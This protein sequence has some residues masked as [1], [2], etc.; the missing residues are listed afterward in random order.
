[1]ENLKNEIKNYIPFNE[2]EE[3]DREIIIELLENEKDILTRDNKKCH[4][5]VSAWIVDSS[6]KK[7]LMCYHNIY[8]SW[9]WL[10]AI[11]ISITLG[12]GLED[13]LMEIVI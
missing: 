11:T 12:L 6:R 7:V 10:G 9:A 3:K 8:N 5:T 4:F 2:Q 1:M 13:T